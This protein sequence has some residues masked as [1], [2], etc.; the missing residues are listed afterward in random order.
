MERREAAPD[1][2]LKSSP[3]QKELPGD[4]IAESSLL[5][6]PR[7]GRVPA[8]KRGNRTNR[9]VWQESLDQMEGGGRRLARCENPSYPTH[10]TSRN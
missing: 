8:K 6:W 9:E 4:L 1:E 10:D 7:E 2:V 3:E 5:P